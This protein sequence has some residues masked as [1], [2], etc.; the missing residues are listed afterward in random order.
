MQLT[1]ASLFSNL[2]N[3][4]AFCPTPIW[5]K[6]RNIRD[7]PKMADPWLRRR[8]NRSAFAV[9][10]HRSSSSRY[11]ARLPQSDLGR[12]DLEALAPGSG[13][14]RWIAKEDRVNSL[15]RL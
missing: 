9:A 1:Q 5:S 11:R 13:S 15:A 6:G 12:T 4:S 2:E 3:A 8:S 14:C 10:I 7:R